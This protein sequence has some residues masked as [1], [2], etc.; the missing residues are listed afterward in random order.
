MFWSELSDRLYVRIR[1]SSVMIRDV[2]W[3]K[4]ADPVDMIPFLSVIV[5]RY[6]FHQEYMTKFREK[7]LVIFMRFGKVIIF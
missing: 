4:S 3:S 7:V 5:S 2:S 6:G 1:L